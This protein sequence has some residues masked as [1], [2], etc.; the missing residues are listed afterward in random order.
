MQHLVCQ[1]RKSRQVLVALQCPSPSCGVLTLSDLGPPIL[2]SLHLFTV[3]NCPSVWDHS[4]LSEKY[5]EEPLCFM[6]VQCYNIIKPN[7]FHFFFLSLLTRHQ[8]L[9][10]TAACLLWQCLSPFEQQPVEGGGW[11]GCLLK[12]ISHLLCIK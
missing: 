1:I 2:P 11:T 4:E 8:H 9:A 3:G 5:W 10:S 7:N 6:S 12:Q